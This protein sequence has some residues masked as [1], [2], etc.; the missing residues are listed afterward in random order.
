MEGDLNLV[1]FAAIL[2]SFVCKLCSAV[3]LYVRTVTTKPHGASSTYVTQH[4]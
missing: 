2:G 3:Y 4:M 1:T